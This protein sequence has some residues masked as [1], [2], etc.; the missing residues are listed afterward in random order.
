MS[1]DINHISPRLMRRLGTLDNVPAVNDDSLSDD[2]FLA[3]WKKSGFTVSKQAQSRFDELLEAAKAQVRLEEARKLREADHQ[4]AGFLD[5]AK[6]FAALSIEEVRQRIGELLS[7]PGMDA[8]VYA[9][10]LEEST[11]DDL[12]SML[13]DL[14]RAK[15]DAS[16]SR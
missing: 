4:T 11:E 14:E 9:R 1:D 6:E 10:K 12:R 2:E 13:V 5:K 15:T 16:E 8:A 7:S 3:A